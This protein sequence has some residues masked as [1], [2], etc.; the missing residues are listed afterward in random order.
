M[1]CGVRG[2]I[3]PY[4]GC[5]VDNGIMPFAPHC[6]NDP[7]YRF[8]DP[9]GIRSA[10]SVG[11]GRKVGENSYGPSLEFIEAV[12]ES[13]PNPKYEDVA[14]SWANQGLAAKFARVL[15]AHPG[16]NIWDAREYLR[17][18][19]SFWTNGWSET[20]GYGRVNE[21]AKVGRLL[22]GP[23]VEFQAVRSRDR[24]H[25]IFTWRNF[26]QSDF[27]ATV[28]ARDDGRILYEGRGTN[29]T[30]EADGDG[31]ATFRYWSKNK[32]GDISRTESYQKRTVNGLESGVYKGCVVFSAPGGGET[33]ARAMAER[34]SQVATNWVCDVALLPGNA[35]YD[36]VKNFPAGDVAGVLTD[37][38]AMTSLA[39][40]NHYRVVIAPLTLLETNSYAFKQDWDRAAAAG[41]LVVVP[42]SASGSTSRLPQA[43]RLSPPRLFSA[44]T[45]GEG[46]TTNRMSFGPGLEFYDAPAVRASADSGITN[47]MDAAGVVAGKLAQILDANPQYNIWDARQ[48]LRQSSSNYSSGWVEDGGYGRP[49]VQPAKIAVLDPAPPL[50]LQAA[51]SASG[52]SVRLEWQNFLQRNF[53]G[54]VVTRGNGQ[55]IYQGTGTNFTWQSDVD[56]NETFHFFSKDKEG[57]LSKAESY[58]VLPVSGLVRNPSSKQISPRPE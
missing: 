6:N 27:A 26:L 33:L 49:P 23:P 39:I 57:R 52:D 8:D 3:A 31:Q 43:R 36:K 47:E 44:V 32:A 53:S 38:S 13:G 41:V 20:N 10:A 17:Q 9:I 51:R 5:A 35:H 29:F 11:G 42:H 58:T 22:P 4:W 55:I 25:V 7:G 18:A 45:V 21:S 16:F 48:H 34:F 54:T 12:P 15:D 19:A 46:V 2:Q 40:S 56:G 28:I 37:Y 14:Q 30:W 24:H 1:N 50:D